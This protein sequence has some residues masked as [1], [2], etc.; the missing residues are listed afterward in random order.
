MNRSE[1]FATLQAPAHWGL[2]DLLSDLHLSTATP[3]T[4]ARL[5]KHLSETPAQAVFLLG[6]I[7]E[8]WIGDDSRF[9]GFEAEAL[10]MLRKASQR[11]D[12]F[13]MVGNRDFLL[14]AEM[15]ADAGAKPLTDPTRLDAFGQRYL[16]V[17]GD[18]Q[19]L[20]DTEYQAFRRM[21]RSPDW[22][23]PFLRRPLAERRAIAQQMRAASMSRQSKQELWADLD[24][25]LCLR[26]LQDAQAGTLVN[27]H[28]HRPGEHALGG[29]L[30]RIVLSDW[31]FDQ[32]E[33]GDVLRIGAEGIQRVAPC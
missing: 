21:A 14:G 12:L 5:D 29:G 23:Q 27:G 24:P 26:M 15:L 13:F 16:L 11:I 19:C 9:E 3:R 25:G 33:R 22:Q 30:R 8:V 28:T 4:F 2:I 6:D 1:T 17:H 31:D 20:E 10:V 32:A 7:F 18:A